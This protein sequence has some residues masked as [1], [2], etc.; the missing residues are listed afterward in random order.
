MS[1]DYFHIKYS[2]HL[3]LF[4]TRFVRQIV[5]KEERREQAR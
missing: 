4:K 2:L 1:D 3:P 5:Y